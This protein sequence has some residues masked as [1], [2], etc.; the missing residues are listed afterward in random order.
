MTPNQALQ[1]T[2]AAEWLLYFERAGSR[3]R[4]LNGLMFGDIHMSSSGPIIGKVFATLGPVTIAPA[5]P[6]HTYFGVA[7]GMMPGVHAL[8]AAPLVS[9]LA[10]ALVAAHVLECL[11]KAYLSR[12][13]SDASV[14]A[15]AVR[16]NLAALWEM[17]AADGLSI[18]PTPPHWAQRLSEVHGSPYYLRYSTGVHGIVLPGAEPMVTEME[19]LLECVQTRLV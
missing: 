2:G 1:W 13:G 14:R 4:P 5:G 16:H 9:S 11:L 17:A 10:L 6:P 7:R 8:S 15:P 3:P 18:P 19:A 12:G